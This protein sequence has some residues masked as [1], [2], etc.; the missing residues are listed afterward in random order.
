VQISAAE[1]SI[2]DEWEH[3]FVPK[4]SGTMAKRPTRKQL[5]A[6]GKALSNPRTREKNETKAAKTLAAG[7][8]KGR[9]K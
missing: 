8:K 5:S 9:T 7:R 3:L 2:L 4:R 1:Q 6:A